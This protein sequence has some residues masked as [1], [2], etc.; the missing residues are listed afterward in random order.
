MEEVNRLMKGPEAAAYLG[1]HLNTLY[2]FAREGRVPASKVG[3]RW[4]FRKDEL[5]RFTSSMV[6]SNDSGEGV[7]SET[8][9]VRTN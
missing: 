8:G 4:R 6:R 5:D 9:N 2:I 7:A 1:I 3:E